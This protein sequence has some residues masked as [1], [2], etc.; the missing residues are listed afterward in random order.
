MYEET[1]FTR[2]AATVT[3]HE[4]AD[5]ITVD[6][7]DASFDWDEVETVQIDNPP[8]TDAFDSKEFYKIPATVAR[9]I[10]QPYRYNDNTVWLKKP[11]DE[12]KRAA[13]S[14]DNAPWTMGHPDSKMVKSVEDIRGFWGDPRYHDRVDDL[15]ADLHIP[16]NDSEA[17]EYLEENSDVSVGF[18]NRIA[19]VDEYDGVVGGSDD[20][21]D[22]DGYQTNMYFDH[23]ASVGVGRCPGEKGCGID[24]P[25]DHGHVSFISDTSIKDGIRDGMDYRITASYDDGFTT[26]YRDEDD[27][28]FAVSPSEGGGEPKFPVNS[29]SDVDDAWKLRN[30]GDISISVS[31]LEERIKRRADAMDCADPEGESDDT[32]CGDCTDCNCSQNISISKTLRIK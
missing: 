20:D 13:W 17:K 31:T 18:Y 22:L 1:Q 7:G 24:S 29:C 4:D 32:D 26:D 8:H 23:V 21:S 6:E 14:L 10:R 28:Y 2:D 15:D 30:H 11:R 25:T 16:I 9:P 19:R 5:G 3:F 27:K 12:L